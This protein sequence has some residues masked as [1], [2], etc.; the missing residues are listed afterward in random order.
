MMML[1]VA[2]SYL[3]K[4]LVDSLLIGNGSRLLNALGAGMLLI[5]LFRALFSVMREY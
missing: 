5:V 1:G 2:S 3:V 4:S